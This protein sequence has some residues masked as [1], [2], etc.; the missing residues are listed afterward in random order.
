MTVIA[1][2]RSGDQG[3]MTRKLID[4]DLDESTSPYRW[5]LIRAKAGQHRRAKY[6]IRREGLRAIVIMAR[7]ERIHNRTKKRIS[8]ARPA[9][10]GYLF[11]RLQK[12]M[13]DAWY[14]LRRCDSVAGVMTTIGARGEAAPFVIPWKVVARLLDKQRR[15]GFDFTE[16]GKRRRGEIVK[17]KRE[18][19]KE[20]FT[21]GR[22]LKVKEGPFAGFDGEVEKFDDRHGHVDVLIQI[23]G[24][25]TQLHFTD[26]AELELVEEPKKKPR[27]A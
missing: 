10:D 22:R 13:P 8:K 6:E 20:I 17:T 2:K 16:D 25:D 7:E 24:R 14:R 21:P 19:L 9:F 5:Y 27:A 12:T 11:L 15:G 26:P 3:Q 1:F 18:Q 4:V 23:F